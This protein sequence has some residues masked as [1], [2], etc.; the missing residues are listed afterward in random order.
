M[1]SRVILTIGAHVKEA[2]QA[3]SNFRAQAAH[4]ESLWLMAGELTKGKAHIAPQDHA[5]KRGVNLREVILIL[6]ANPVAI[7]RTPQTA[8]LSSPGKKTN[9]GEGKISH[10]SPLPPAIANGH[11]IAIE[12]FIF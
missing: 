4:N 8:F 9:K 2:T 10:I 11:K 5:A 1:P 12:V 6:P 3:K 7:K